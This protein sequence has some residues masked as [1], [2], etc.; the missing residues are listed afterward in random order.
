MLDAGDGIAHRP[1]S[2]PH[3]ELLAA[4]AVAV[5][6]D[7]HLRLDLP[8]PIQRALDAEIRRAGG[9]NCADAGRGEHRHHRLRHVR[10]PA[11]DAVSPFHAERHQRLA[12]RHRFGQ[13][14]PIGERTPLAAFE[15]RDQRHPVVREAQQVLGEVQPRLGKPAA[16]RKPLAIDERHLARFA[17]NPA[18]IPN[19]PPELLA[20]AHRPPM[21]HRVIRRRKAK[22]LGKAR[23]IGLGNA[24]GAG[25]PEGGL[26]RQRG[27][28]G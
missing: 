25:L 4:V 28:C 7:Q 14:L 17:N 15:H 12:E 10:Q 18:E 1:R 20:I 6:G 5:A 16:P 13:Q 22:R 3:V 24:L 21:Q 9:P 23:Q 2:L 26:V 11:G 27:A 19:R 8:E